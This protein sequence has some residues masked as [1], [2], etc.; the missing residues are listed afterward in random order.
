MCAGKHVFARV[1][2][3]LPWHGLHRPVGRYKGNRR[4]QPFSCSGQYRCMAFAQLTCRP[5]LRDIGTCLRARGGQA[6]SH[7]HPRRRGGKHAFQRQQRPG[8]EAPRPGP[9]STVPEPGAFHIMDRACPEFRAPP[10][11]A[12]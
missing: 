11:T 3:H 1:M 7:G 5:G 12:P 6:P 2:D 4:V 8:P 9:D 10:H